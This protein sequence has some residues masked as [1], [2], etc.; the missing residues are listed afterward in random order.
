MNEVNEYFLSK[1][2]EKIGEFVNEGAILADIGSDHAYLPI[3][4]VK[5]GKCPRAIAGELN[6]GPFAS[7]IEQINKYNLS[8]QIKAK[9][10]NGLTVLEGEAVESVVVAGMGGPLIASI[11]E[12]GK[13]FLV[14]VEQLVL[15]PNVA[16][17]HCRLWLL[18]NEWSLIDEAIVEE[19]DHVYEILVAHR[20]NPQE[21][22]GIE[23]EKELSMGPHLLKEK[24]AAF[25]KKWTRELK[26]LEKVNNQLK[27]AGDQE[28][29]SQKKQVIE[30]KLFW[31][32]EEL[33]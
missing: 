22:Y 18:N 5:Q 12:D 14:G 27:R 16:A 26:Q 29:L 25:Q 20:G 6:Q 2:L 28:K 17:D 1:R 19:D 30:K 21:H 8:G 11:L 7:A 15:Q 3:H 31:L 4:L 33:S 23:L 24:N 13:N 9:L 32:K 10:G